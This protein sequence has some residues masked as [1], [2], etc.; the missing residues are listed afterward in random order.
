MD[1]QGTH[2]STSFTADPEDSQ[3][4]III[5]LEELALVNSTDTKLTLDSR[6]K[7]RSLEQGTGESLHS[8]SELLLI[9]KGIVKAKDANVFFTS[10]LLG[11]DQTG[12]TVDTDNQTSSDLGIKGT[13]VTSLLNAKDAANP[14]DDFV[15]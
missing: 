13:G 11:F 7:R 6:N 5:E 1:T 15:R 8:L 3:V 12:G 10:S 2:V 14:S 4:S 9:V